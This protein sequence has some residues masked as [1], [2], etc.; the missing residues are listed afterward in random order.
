M[1]G[2]F[3]PREYPYKVN[4]RLDDKLMEF[5][6]AVSKELRITKSEAIRLILNYAFELDPQKIREYYDKVKLT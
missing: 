4:V 3:G 1:R 2:R 5:V 6:N